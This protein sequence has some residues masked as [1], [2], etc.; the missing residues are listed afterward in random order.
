[1]EITKKE[2]EK[3]KARKQRSKRKGREEKAVSCPEFTYIIFHGFL[4]GVELLVVG[5]A[6]WG[7][8]QP[9]RQRMNTSQVAGERP[10]TPGLSEVTRETEK[11]EVRTFTQQRTQL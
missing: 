11:L 1:M 4:W 9:G 3:K 2:G 6:T 8:N 7:V 10:C 5:T